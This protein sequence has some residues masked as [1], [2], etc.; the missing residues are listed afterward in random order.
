M[1]EEWAVKVRSELPCRLF[2]FGSAIYKGGE[3]FDRE[4]SD[5]DIV[6]L[7]PNPNTALSRFDAIKILKTFK[8][9]LELESIPTLARL[10]CSEPAVSIVTITEME[11][12]S[13][14]HKSGARS[15]FNKNSFYDL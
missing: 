3:Q 5:L 14:I 9:K 4:Q 6:C 2:L 10:T 15:F 12:H 8:A 13:N 7:L 1:C 11:L